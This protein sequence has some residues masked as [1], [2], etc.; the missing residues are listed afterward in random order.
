MIIT[1]N[2]IE[3][4]IPTREDIDFLIRE[5]QDSETKFLRDFCCKN[6]IEPYDFLNEWSKENIVLCVEDKPIYL[7]ALIE[8]TLGQIE[9]WT[10]VVTDVTNLITLCKYS[11]RVLK[12]W[13]KK[14]KEIYATML[15]FDEE[16][17]KFVGWLGFEKIGEDANYITY[18]LKGE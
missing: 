2:K 11:K 7:A 5:A 3:L 15:R 1:E 8:N 9:L 18:V 10:V 17:R 12:D 4:R 6:E 14:Y 16:N 13:V